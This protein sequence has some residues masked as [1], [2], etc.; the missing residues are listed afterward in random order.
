MDM[1]TFSIIIP[2]Y[3][4]EK[5]LEEA[6]RSVTEQS[7]KDLELL[8]VDDCSPDGSAALAESLCRE[9]SRIRLLRMP[10]N[11]GAAAARNAGISAAAGRYVCFLDSDDVYT[12]GLLQS[13]ADQLAADPDVVLWGLVEE[14][15]TKEDRLSRT[16]TIL[17]ET[18]GQPD[19]LLPNADAV[20]RTVVDLEQQ[21]LYGYLW[22]KAY[23]AELIRGKSIPK[24]PFNEDEMFNIS[25]FNEVNSMVL[26]P[27]VGTCYRIR[28]EGSLTHRELPE[29]YPISMR[30]I[31][32]LVKQ[33]KAWGTYDDA[34]KEKLANQYVRYLASALER[35]T[36]KAA[37][38]GRK[39]RRA[40][41]DRVFRSDLY[42][43]LIPAADPASRALKVLTTALKKQNKTVCLCIGRAI[44]VIKNRMTG[45]FYRA[46]NG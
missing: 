33:Q 21:S 37:G 13:V 3:K 8:L 29:Y 38:L 26:L 43:E 45:I 27:V 44:A 12:D 39:E 1:P 6:V 5:T 20:R 23:R 9:D 10:E 36:H 30:R 41:L 40:F 11:G 2:V 28:G 34:A 22:N 7:F 4:A 16:V 24:Q 15:R 31:A 25:L 42:R 17:P 46:K 19:R 18:D 35:N 14:Y 32:G